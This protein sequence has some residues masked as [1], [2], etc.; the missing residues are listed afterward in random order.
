MPI[1]HH[2]AVT[3][4]VSGPEHQVR[5]SIEILVALHIGHAAADHREEHPAGAEDDATDGR[6]RTVTHHGDGT[7]TWEWFVT[8]PINNYDVA[9]NA[10]VYDH[11]SEVYRGEN[12]PLTLDFWPLAFH[13]QA[14][15]QPGRAD[16]LWQ[17]AAVLPREGRLAW[18]PR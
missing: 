17:A 4:N 16:R 12:G 2:G 13:R 5:L 6:L 18:A 7:T 8:N 10:G 3:L 11:F 1:E 9:V 14:A 15:E